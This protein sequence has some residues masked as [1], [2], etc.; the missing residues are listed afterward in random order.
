[1]FSNETRNKYRYLSHAKLWSKML[2]I[3][4]QNLKKWITHRIAYY[5]GG[6]QRDEGGKV[7]HV[8]MRKKKKEKEK[9]IESCFWK[10]EACGKRE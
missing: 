1:M 8:S 3:L 6:I 5:R 9:E 7:F 4:P 2:S 10:G